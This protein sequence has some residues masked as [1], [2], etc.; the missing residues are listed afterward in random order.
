LQ[1]LTRILGPIIGGQL[2]ILF[3]SPAPACMGII[4]LIFA[5]AIFKTKNRQN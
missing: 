3:G 4:L 5:F 1:A 2:Y